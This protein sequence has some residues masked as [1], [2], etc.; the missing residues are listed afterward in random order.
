MLRIG[1]FLAFLAMAM[2]SQPLTGAADQNDARL[3][4]L[5]EILLNAP[6]NSPEANAAQEE[7]WAVWGEAPTATGRILMKQGVEQMQHLEYDAAIVTFSAL[8]EFVPEFAEAWNKRATLH[9]LQG[10]F[11]D[12]LADINETLKLEPR[13]FGAQSGTGLIF[14]AMEEWEAA[15]DAYEKALRLNPHMPQI[16]TRV[17]QLREE[18]K[19]REL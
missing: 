15:L 13:H 4:H 19:G 5:F 12:S 1:M 16:A 18:L 7:I 17:E 6:E 3:S 8:I 11:A 9:Y 10:N 14:D 2:L